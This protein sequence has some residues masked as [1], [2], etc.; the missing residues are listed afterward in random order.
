MLKAKALREQIAA[1]NQ[2]YVDGFDALLTMEQRTKLAFLRRA[3]R[4]GPLFPAFRLFGL[5][6]LQACGPGP[7]R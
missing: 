1:A 4:A 7:L 3:E 6:P 2:V 5:L